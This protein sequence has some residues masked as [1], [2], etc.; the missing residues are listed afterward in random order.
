M[1][2]YIICIHEHSIHYHPSSP[3]FTS[4]SLTGCDEHQGPHCEAQ[5]QFR[6]HKVH[7]L[8][9][10]AGFHFFPQL[11]C[12]HWGVLT[13][14]VKARC[15]IEVG[16]IRVRP[17]PCKFPYRM[18]PV[19]CPCAFRLRRLAQNDSRGRR[20]PH[21][22]PLVTCPCAFRL[23]RLAQNDSR[24]QREPRKMP[25][26]TCPCAFRL[27]RLAQNDSRGQRERHFPCKFPHKMPLVTCPCAFRL[28]RLAQNDVPGGVRSHFSCKFRNKIALVKSPCAFSIMQARTNGCRGISVRHFS[29][30]FPHKIALS[31]MFM[32][33]STAQARTKRDISYRILPKDLLEGAYTEIL[34]RDLLWISC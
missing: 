12:P 4:S 21:K 26:V 3:S 28:R 6:H 9:A 24:G 11:V 25:L 29:C 7:I 20:E 19:R 23:R 15:S 34:L 33:I 16:I 1:S 8:A 30:K 5:S 13:V 2:I 32:C 10:S 22:M 31:E 14:T 17:I 18:A 27:R